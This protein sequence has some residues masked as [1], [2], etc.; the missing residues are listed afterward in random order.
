M[1]LHTGWDKFARDL[2]LEPGCQLTFLYEGDGEMIVKVFDDTACRRHYHTGESGSNTIPA[3]EFKLP[4]FN[5]DDSD[6]S[7]F[8]EWNE[9]FIADM[10]AEAVEQ[11]AQWGEEEQFQG[12]QEQAAILASFNTQCFRGLHEEEVEETN[13]ANF[14]HVVEISG[15]RVATQ[16]ASCILMA[17]ER[18]RLLE[19]NAQRQVE[20]ATHEQAR[21]AQNEES[22]Q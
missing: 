7:Q 15:Q 22:R 13:D 10:E 3:A 21:L 4:A 2:A 1:Y 18:Q 11:A 5:F 6:D 14:E 19:L 17:A 20:T 9:A 12:D 8:D 16:E